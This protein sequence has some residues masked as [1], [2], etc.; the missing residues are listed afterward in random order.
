MM[1]WEA[2]DEENSQEVPQVQ[3]DVKEATHE[4]AV[5]AV[6]VMADSSMQCGRETAERST[7]METTFC[8][9]GTQT[10]ITKMFSTDVQTSSE[11]IAVESNV[12]R[13]DD[14]KA[15]VST[16]LGVKETKAV[17]RIIFEYYL[18]DL[19]QPCHQPY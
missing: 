19:A 3:W 9:N 8:D 17:Y 14:I 2:L 16:S 18:A 12:V 11:C 7:S 13:T 10:E 4:L 1:F 5:Q 15:E 6:P